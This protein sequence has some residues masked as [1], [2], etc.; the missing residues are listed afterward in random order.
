M[1]ECYLLL[2][3]GLNLLRRHDRNQEANALQFDILGELVGL[4]RNEDSSKQWQVP[5]SL[6]SGIPL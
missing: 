2:H 5:P 3:Y 1:I 4:W 6:A